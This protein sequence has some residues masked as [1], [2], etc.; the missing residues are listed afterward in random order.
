MKNEILSAV[1]RFIFMDD[2]TGQAGLVERVTGARRSLSIP[3]SR[4]RAQAATEV[5][6]LCQFVMRRD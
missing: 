2:L 3:S 5:G 6:A 4:P 1:P